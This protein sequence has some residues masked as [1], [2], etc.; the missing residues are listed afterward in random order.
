MK[1]RISIVIL[2]AIVALCLSACGGGNGGTTT[3]PLPTYTIGGTVSGLLGTGLLLQDNDGVGLQIYANGSFTFPTPIASGGTYNVTLSIQPSNPVQICAVTNGSGTAGANVTSVQVTCPS[4]PTE[5]VLYSFGSQ[6]DGN[7]PT[8]NLVFDESGNLYGTTSRGGA[9]G[10]GTVFKLSPN[11][12]QWTETVIYNFCPAV[13]CLDGTTPLSSLLFDAAGNLY[14][15]TSHGGLYGIGGAG[16]VAFELTPQPDGTW[17]ET[18]LYNFGNGTDSSGP[19]ALV[20]D[21]AGNLYGAAGG[22]ST[23]F[24]PSNCGTIFE[25]SPG[26]NGQW[27]ERVLYNFCSQASCADGTDPGGVVFDSAG[28]LYGVTALG[29]NPVTQN[30]TV[31]ELTPDKNGQW[32][33]TVLYMFQGGETDGWDPFGGVVMDSSGNLYGIT[34]AGYPHNT[35]IVFEVTHQPGGQWTESV[36]HGFCSQPNCADG[37]PPGGLVF[38][39]AGNLYGT[40]GADGAFHCGVVYELTPQKTG[41][42]PVVVPYT[43]QCGSDGAYPYSGLILDPSGNLYGVT[44][45]GGTAPY[46]GTVFRVTP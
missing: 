14:G 43:F 21:K 31:F 2:G 13:H 29:G 5:E 15:A 3:P 22:G 6:P 9:Y 40:A 19:G 32:V 7:Y 33:E 17:T 44:L 27:T 11:Q 25:L 34:Q 28:N 38:D 24:C 8:A 30:G 12:G 41:S 45:Q 23:P 4:P 26:P 36:L 46:Y 20:F 37:S 16:G 42:W 10:N 1:S 39:K 35:G 18:V